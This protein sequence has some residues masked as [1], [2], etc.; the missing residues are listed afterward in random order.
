MELSRSKALDKKIAAKL[1]KKI[2]PGYTVT[3]SVTRPPYLLCSPFFE[4]FDHFLSLRLQV[5]KKNVCVYMCV[6]V[7]VY[8][9]VC[10]CVYVRVCVC[11]HFLCFIALKL[12]TLITI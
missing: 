9:C 4:H 5:R 6:C 2:V 12:N 7:C 3:N 10:V 1:M 11:S 8:V